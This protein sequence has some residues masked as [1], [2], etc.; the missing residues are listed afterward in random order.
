MRSRP[1]AARA[2]EST[3]FACAS[4]G[5]LTEETTNVAVTSGTPVDDDGE[6]ITDSHGKPIKTPPCEDDAVATPTRKDTTP[7]GDGSSR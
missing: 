5:P 4:S 7:P 2:G 1:G 3:R 6:P